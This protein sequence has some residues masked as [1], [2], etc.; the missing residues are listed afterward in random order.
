MH[1]TTTR[2]DS[3]RIAGTHPH[4]VT[5]K[6]QDGASLPSTV[7]VG[8]YLE[9]T[10][11]KSLLRK[12]VHWHMQDSVLADRSREVALRLALGSSRIRILRQLLTEAVLISLLGGA[13]GL[14]G[15]IVL[16]RRMS[17]WQPFPGAPIHLPV[18]PD[19]TIY[20][21]ALVLALVSGF[22]FGIVPVRQVLWTNPYQIVESGSSGRVGRRMTVRD[23]LLMVQ[24]AI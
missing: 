23:A 16:L 11:A 2:V 6:V 15:S 3:Q 12:V 4:A 10:I 13:V 1:W 20:G 14:L 19:A 22:L 17:M 24:I 18:N 21:V 7:K 8:A 5:S 9:K